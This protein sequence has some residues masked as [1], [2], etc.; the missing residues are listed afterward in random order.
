MIVGFH[1]NE[2][3][4]LFAQAATEIGPETIRIAR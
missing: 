4:E 3:A 2:V 1:L